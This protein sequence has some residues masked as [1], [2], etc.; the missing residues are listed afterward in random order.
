MLAYASIPE[1]HSAV[2]SLWFRVRQRGYVRANQTGSTKAAMTAVLQS[3]VARLKEAHATSA[4]SGAQMSYGRRLGLGMPSFQ[5]TASAASSAP[6]TATYS[7]SFITS[8]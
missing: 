8:F 6:R 3:P 2:G 5:R 4:R 1:C 7:Q